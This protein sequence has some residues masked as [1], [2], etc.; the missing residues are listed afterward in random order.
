MSLR[1]SYS[2]NRSWFIHLQGVVWVAVFSILFQGWLAAQSYSWSLHREVNLEKE[3]LDFVWDKPT[4]TSAGQIILQA[5]QAETTE[6][7]KY[8]QYQDL[9]GRVMRELKAGEFHDYRSVEYGQIYKFKDAEGRWGLYDLS[10]TKQADLNFAQPDVELIG[11]YE[12]GIYIGRTSGYGN[13]LHFANP[14]R[15][16]YKIIDPIYPVDEKVYWGNTY[17]GF[18]NHPRNEILFQIGSEAGRATLY[19]NSDGEVVWRE[20]NA[21]AYPMVSLD[22]NRIV[23]LKSEQGMFHGTVEIFDPSGKSISSFSARYSVK[24]DAISETGKYLVLVNNL[25]RVAVYDVESATRLVSKIILEN[26]HPICD[27]VVNETLGILLVYLQDSRTKG[28]RFLQAYALDDLQGEPLWEYD[29]GEYDRKSSRIARIAKLSISG[30][31]RELAVQNGNW[32][33]ILS[34]EE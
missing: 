16:I 8:R 32:F 1:L 28:R 3:A 4:E 24:A 33:G 6:G 18:Y 22:G 20:L 27:T 7:K 5:I 14:A 25:Y 9:D 2:C 23:L 29:L 31:G 19:F 26:Q 10:N 30:D 21:G 12:G 34:L 11:F 13:V 17:S 15:D